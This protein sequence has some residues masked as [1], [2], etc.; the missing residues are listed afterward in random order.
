MSRTPES[1]APESDLQVFKSGKWSLVCV[2]SHEIFV[3]PVDSQILSKEAT[4]AIQAEIESWLPIDA[5]SISFGE[6]SQNSNPSLVVACDG[7]RLA[8]EIPDQTSCI[9]CIPYALLATSAVL[10]RK[11]ADFTLAIPAVGSKLLD[12]ITCRDRCIASWEMK[13]FETTPLA[14]D[15]FIGDVKRLEVSSQTEVIETQIVDEEIESILTGRRAPLLNICNGPLQSSVNP[16]AP[17]KIPTYACVL[18]SLI[19]FALVIC[20]FVR[21]SF[22]YRAEQVASVARQE[23]IFRRTFPGQQLPV[24]I[25]ARFQS[26]HRELQATRRKKGTPGVASAL[27]V[28]RSLLQAFPEN[29][30]TSVSVIFCTPGQLNGFEAKANSYVESDSLWKAFAD[31]GF[32]LPPNSISNRSGQ[33][34]IKWQNVAWQTRKKSK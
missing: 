29:E 30:G 17:S 27:P 26:E 1:S 22:E 15:Y 20:S 14:A 31:H 33:I 11:Q 10:R 4:S 23:E 9:A 13:N 16:F 32:E 19:C 12:V 28:F 21:N 34:N 7:D 18:A 8:R 2:P 25:L 24:G 3:V 6:L 5:E